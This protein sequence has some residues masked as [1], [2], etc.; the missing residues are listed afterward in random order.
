ME[1]ELLAAQNPWWSDKDAIKDDDKVK[2]VIE[3]GEKIQFDLQEE[4]QVLVGPRQ[5]GKTTALKYDIY[6]KIT[7]RG[8]DP[9]SIMYYSLDTVRNFEV[10]SDILNTFVTGNGKRFVYLDEISF[11]NEWQRAIKQ[12]LD[13]RISQNAVLYITGSSSINLKKELMP[14][15]KMRFAEFLPLSFR[16]FL[17]S[18]GSTQLKRFLENKKAGSFKDAVFYSRAAMAYSEEISKWFAVYMKTGGYP[19]AIFDYIK[20]G[21]ISDSLYDVHWNAFVSDVSKDRKSVEIATAVAYGILES[22]SSKMNLSSIARMQGI[23]SHITVREYL[24]SFENLF[25][26]KSVFPVAGRKYVFRK[27][28]KVYLNDPFLY[29]MFAKK[30]NHLDK[31]SEPKVAEGI[32]FNHLYRFANLGKTMT[33]P[34]TS[35]GFYSGKKEVDF[36]MGNFGFEL[37]WQNNTN[38]SDFPKVDIKNRI[39]LSKKTLKYENTENTQIIPLPLFLSML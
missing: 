11:V 31:N 27:E 7:Q 15:R 3:T 2:D 21:R 36:V 30:T 12:F 18:F 32:L 10:I 35:I 13:S 5:L 14:G 9:H 37:K 26:S 38:I 6:K 24:E 22:Y 1:I 28:R 20:N 33:E 29:N 16:N 23:K 19:D 8:I 4:N 17:F 25:V 39:I 34:K